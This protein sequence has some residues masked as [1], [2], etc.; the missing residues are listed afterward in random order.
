MYSLYIEKNI[1]SEDFLKKVLKKYHIE[2]DIFYNEYGKPYLKNNEL[3]FNI[4]HS[5]EYI[6][7]AVS[8]K[9]IGVDI[10]H[11]TFNEKTADRICTKE[12]RKKVKTDLDFTKIWTKKEAYIKKIGMGLEYG[13]KNVDTTKIDN[14]D[15]YK[16]DDY[17]IAICYEK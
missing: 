3:Y 15:I 7:I 10:E 1:S 4:S 8:D 5:K 14:I 13:M 6:V 2:Y 11:L 12:E 16:K 17:I 9:E